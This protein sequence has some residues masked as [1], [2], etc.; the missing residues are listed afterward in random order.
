MEAACSMSMVMS[1]TASTS[2]TFSMVEMVWSLG[3]METIEIDFLP[4]QVVVDVD[5]VEDVD[6]GLLI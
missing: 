2:K 1:M 4:T 3:L 5:V 6:D